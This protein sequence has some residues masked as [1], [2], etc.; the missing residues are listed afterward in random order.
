MNA[1]DDYKAVKEEEE[2][3]IRPRDI[4]VCLIIRIVAVFFLKKF[5]V[6]V[7]V[8][9]DGAVGKT[10]LCNVFVKRE[11]PMD[12]HPTCFENYAKEMVVDGEVGDLGGR[13][14]RRRRRRS[15]HKNLLYS[16][17]LF[18]S[19]CQPNQYR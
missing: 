14:R 10:C 2:E 16:F 11:F 6:Q 18:F 7:V 1:T 17:P 15:T 13:R 9:G 12:Y 19:I 8:V 3:E 5:L 4:K